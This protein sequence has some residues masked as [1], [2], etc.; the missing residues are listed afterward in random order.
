MPEKVE[1][2]QEMQAAIIRELANQAD[3]LRERATA[4]DDLARRLKC[5]GWAHIMSCLDD[6]TAN[7][8]GDLDSLKVLQDCYA[9]W[10]H[11]ATAPGEGF[12]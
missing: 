7:D 6:E 3:E 12:W 10:P 2:W 11:C 9:N 5:G 4:I 1:N 8:Y